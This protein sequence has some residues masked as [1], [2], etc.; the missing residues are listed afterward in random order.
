MILDKNR[1]AGGT[2]HQQIHLSP[3]NTTPR[4]PLSSGELSTPRPVM[5]R[6]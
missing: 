6:G 1:R 2:I 5:G 4:S 3:H